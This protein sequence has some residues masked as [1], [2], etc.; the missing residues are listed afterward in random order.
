MAVI[1]L[2]M[3]NFTLPTRADQPDLLNA[4]D[5]VFLSF[6]IC[7]WLD[8]PVSFSNPRCGGSSNSSWNHALDLWERACS[9]TCVE[10]T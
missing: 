2:M 10:Y 1:L 7:S 4:L 3:A 9:L 5:L 8:K 6:C